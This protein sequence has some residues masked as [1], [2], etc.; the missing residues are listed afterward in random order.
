MTTKKQE[1]EKIDK[2]SEEE[3]EVYLQ[4]GENGWQWTVKFLF[5]LFK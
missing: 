5:K 1:K 4:K 2:M 3:K